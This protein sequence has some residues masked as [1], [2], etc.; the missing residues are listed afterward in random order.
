[1]VRRTAINININTINLPEGSSLADPDNNPQ[2][3]GKNLAVT[4]WAFK[5]PVYLLVRYIHRLIV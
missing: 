4:P 3:K 1:M 2:D 5:S